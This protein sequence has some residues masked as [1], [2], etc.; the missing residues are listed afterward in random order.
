MVTFFGSVLYVAERYM[1]QS[2]VLGSLQ[3]GHGELF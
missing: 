2:F 1:G 3:L